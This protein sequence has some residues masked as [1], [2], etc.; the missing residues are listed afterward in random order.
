MEVRLELVELTLDPRDGRGVIVLEHRPSGRAFPVWVD[1]RDA[2][3]IARATAGRATSRP[4]TQELLYAV[5]LALGAEVRHAALTRVIGGV[6][7]AELCLVH[8]D[9]LFA[10]DARP[11]DAIAVA[12]RAGAPILVDD[13]LL[14]QVAA[15]VREAEARVL[16]PSGAAAAEPALQS[17]A[18]R[19]NILLEH[20]SGEHIGPPSEA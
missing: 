4:D 14:E 19:W 3:A 5:A 18:E 11:S 10:L 8:G 16:P 20:L 7:H 6:V 2:A 12:L 9:E 1:E 17:T 13:D 15:R